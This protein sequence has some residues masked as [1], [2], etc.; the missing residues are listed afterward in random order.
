MTDSPSPGEARLSVYGPSHL[1][2]KFRLGRKSFATVDI[3]S[4]EIN[5]DVPDQ[6]TSYDKLY[7]YYYY[8]RVPPFALSWKA[9]ED[10]FR[11]NPEFRLKSFSPRYLPP[12]PFR[13]KRTLPG[14]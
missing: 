11:R 10:L 13:F 6:K 12:P 4:G 8:F 14:Y 9:Q 2:E 1:L 5:D 7:N 3:F